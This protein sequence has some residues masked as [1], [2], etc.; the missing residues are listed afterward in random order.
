MANARQL[1]TSSEGLAIIN[2][3]IEG[4]PTQQKLIEFQ[5]KFG[6]KEVTGTLGMQ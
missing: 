5:K 1:L 2:S 6:I 4:T 3:L